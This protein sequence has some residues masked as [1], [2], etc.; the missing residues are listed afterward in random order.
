M[1]NE[2]SS[3]ASRAALAASRKISPPPIPADR[4][5][6]KQCQGDGTGAIRIGRLPLQGQRVRPGQ[7]D[8]APLIGPGG[9]EPDL[10]AVGRC[11]SNSP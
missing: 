1:A 10:F 7:V 11:D 9:Y 3:A 4:L 8:D 6:W 5:P 2:A